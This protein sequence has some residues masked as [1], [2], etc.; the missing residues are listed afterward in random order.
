MNNKP[1][2]MRQITSSVNYII[3]EHEYD[4]EHDYE[5]TDVKIIKDQIYK[6]KDIYQ[7]IHSIINNIK[8]NIIKNCHNLELVKINMYIYDQK[9]IIHMFI[10]TISN[11][12]TKLLNLEE[13]VI[14]K[15]II[16][17]IKYENKIVFCGI[18]D[19]SHL[20]F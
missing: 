5:V 17:Y 18:Y 2:S 8:D 16:I 9:N 14:D 10:L 3:N 6:Y 20:L 19:F 7:Y 11:I 1:F 15:S 13:F 12:I 4:Y